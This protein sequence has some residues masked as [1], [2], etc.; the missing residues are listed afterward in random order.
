MGKNM[1]ACSSESQSLR[2]W[3]LDAVLMTR[4]AGCATDN[5]PE[6]TYMS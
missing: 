1:F 4:K 5:S 3:D 2:G 6:E